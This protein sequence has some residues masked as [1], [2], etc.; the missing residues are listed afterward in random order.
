MTCYLI[1]VN[2][3]I[4]SQATRF[5][6]HYILIPSTSYQTQLCRTLL[7]TRKNLFQDSPLNNSVISLSLVLIIEC[8]QKQLPF[9]EKDFTCDVDNYI[10]T[11]HSLPGSLHAKWKKHVCYISEW[12]LPLLLLIAFSFG[13]EC[14]EELLSEEI[15][16][17]TTLQPKWLHFVVQSCTSSDCPVSFPD[18]LQSLPT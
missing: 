1:I 14:P 11:Y 18:S 12:F 9:I 13:V 15:Q 3:L 7:P 2:M 6:S 8:Y 4:L 10:S 16:C 17:P 5:L